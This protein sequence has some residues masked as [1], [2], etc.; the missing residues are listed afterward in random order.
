MTPLRRPSD[1]LVARW[2]LIDEAQ[3]S[4]DLQYYLWASDSAGYLLLQRLIA[5]ADRGV[6]VRMII[7]DLKFRRRTRS[8]ASLC[9][10]PN[11]EIRLFN[12]WRMR[13]SMVS[14]SLEFAIRFG[15][16]DQ[17]M[18][19]KLLIAD[20]ERTIFGGRNIAETHFGLDPVLNV[21]D[22][23]LL[24]EGADVTD[25]AAVF[26]AYWE[27]PAAVSG[28]AF[29][30][31]VTEA[32]LRTTR[33]SVTAELRKREGTLSTVRAEMD[34][35]EERLRSMKRPLREHAMRVVC[36]V[37]DP[38]PGRQ[39]TQVLEGLRELVRSAREEIVVATP[40][41]VP[42]GPDVEWYRQLVDQGVRVRVLTNSLAS[43]PGTISNSGL[44]KQRAA[45]VRAGVELHELRVDA[46]TKPEWETS[47]RAGRY[48][49]LH[50]KLYVV[51][52]E[53]MFVGSINLDPRSKFIN[54]EMG[55]L[56]TD[57]D[58]AR[59]T[60]DAIARFME[61]ENSWRVVAGS[62]ERV[63]WRSDVETL[64]RQPARNLA[65]RVAD[66]VLGLLPIRQYI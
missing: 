48:L 49:G 16:L 47:P 17:R 6:R 34:S 7:D 40:F 12:P 51:D 23:D 28:T 11:V 65:Q 42:S 52:R 4:L 19:N 64:H 13:S 45:L 55:V 2:A 60:A 36:D 26:Q 30:H 38:S 41:F 37:P 27:S 18:H 3:R 62:G 66:W 22:F 35:W 20:A 14:E 29:A 31:S 53:Q 10:H 57:A 5:A 58:L 24:V 63:T 33:D 8:V 46:A 44:K 59:E 9:L 21:V 39:R 32:D 56:L 25:L 54:T 50:A 61:G 15:R 43:N 1:G